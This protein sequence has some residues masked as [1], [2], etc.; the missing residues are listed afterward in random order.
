MKKELL[1]ALR[2]KFE[3]VADA[4]LTRVADK[5]AKT[6]TTEEQVKAAVDGV[7]F[8][9]VIDSYTESR[10]TEAQKTAVGNYEKTHNLKDGKPVQ[11][12]EPEPKEEEPADMPAWAKSIIETNKALTERIAKMDGERINSA[13][14]KQLEEITNKLPETLRKS[15][16]RVSVDGLTDEQ[17]NELLG[18]VSDEVEGIVKD[19]NAKGAVFGTPV[20][21]GNAGGGGKEKEASEAEVNAVVDRISI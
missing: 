1:E 11:K 19:I 20:N 8:Q 15:Y 14:K 18:E 16:G 3:G 12:Q 10:V 7:T 9:Q 21:H 17:F 5:L 13:R 6:A 4:V 2:A